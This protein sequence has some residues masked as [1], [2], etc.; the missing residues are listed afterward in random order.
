MKIPVQNICCTLIGMFYLIGHRCCGIW[1]SI[2]D[3]VVKSGKINVMGGYLKKLYGE[4]HV[5][6]KS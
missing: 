6:L 1:K 4:F 2:F 3:Y 5:Y